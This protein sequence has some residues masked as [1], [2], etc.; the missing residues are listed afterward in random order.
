MIHPRSAAALA[1][2]TLGALFIHAVA[3]SERSIT[4]VTQ[5]D[6]AQVEAAFEAYRDA[7]AADDGAVAAAWVTQETLRHAAKL[8]DLALYATLE[9]LEAEPVGSEMHVLYL[10]MRLS[11]EK[12]EAMSPR[13]VFAFAVERGFITNLWRAEDE[14]RGVEQDENGLE[15]AALRYRGARQMEPAL[16]F[17]REAGGWRIDL[18]PEFDWLTERTEIDARDEELLAR[19]IARSRVEL[20]AGHILE[21]RHLEPLRPR[22][23]G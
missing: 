4:E 8:R 19:D 9:E 12:L 10:R 11:P 16:R 20:F 23:A 7:A 17:Q 1:A 14:L 22:P 6:A 5:S 13:E 21:P 15:L 18:L 3:C 2:A